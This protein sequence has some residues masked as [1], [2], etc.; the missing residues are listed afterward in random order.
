MEAFIGGTLTLFGSPLSVLIFFCGLIGGLLFGAIPGINM[1]TLAAIFLPFSGLLS[2]SD[3]IMFY[4]V[5]YCSGTYGGAVTAIL[6]NIPGAPENAPTAFDGYPMTQKGEAGKAIGAAVICSAF[7]GIC[8]VLL[9]MLA[10][11]LLAEVAVVYFGPPEIFALVFF[12]IAVASSVSA[13][14][15]WKGWLSVGLGLMIATVGLDPV[16]GIERYNFGY[17]YLMAGLHFIPIILGFF[18]V[19]EVFVQAE[20]RVRGIFDMPKF[21]TSFPSVAEFWKLKVAV[22]RSVGLGFFAGILPGIGA[23]LA[24]FLSYNEAVRWSKTPEKFG[25]GELEG[26]VA[27]ETA[28]NAAT[29]AAMIPLLA[30]GLPGGALTAMMVGVFQMHDIEPGPLVFVNSSEL[31]WVVFAAMF[32]ANIAILV[33]GFLETKTVLHLLKIP[34]QYLAPAI[35]LL[36]T[37]GA[38]AVRSLPMDVLVMFVAGLL[39][40]LLRRTGYSVA[41]I[42]LGLILGKIGEQNFAQAMQ[43]VSYDM[44]VFISRPIVA[45]LLFAG[46]ATIVTNLVRALRGSLKGM[47]P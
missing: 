23:T 47:Q 32:Y 27:S 19:S 35:L 33:L 5:L 21:S 22:A 40:Y 11:P 6:F 46:S 16:A 39:A 8:S 43:M 3:A 28:N 1:L 20:K 29:G 45:V 13:K 26:V 10:T 31:V 34:F 30:L 17:V 42:I 2:A 38:Y 24:A 15:L 36:S 7:G 41:G 14:T 37:V 12:G 4:S 44:W 9:M 18:A 25:K